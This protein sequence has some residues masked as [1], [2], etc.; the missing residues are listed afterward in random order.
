MTKSA[1]V[2]IALSLFMRLWQTLHLPLRLTFAHVARIYI[3]LYVFV[4]VCGGYSNGSIS[5]GWRKFVFRLCSQK[6][7][8]ALLYCKYV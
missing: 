2:I 5:S 7:K 6:Y 4:R 8:Q 1:C 3:A